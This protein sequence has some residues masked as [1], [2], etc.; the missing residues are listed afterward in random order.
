MHVYI[1]FPWGTQSSMLWP[2]RLNSEPLSVCKIST[3]YLPIV[4]NH[5]GLVLYL[6]SLGRF[7]A[8]SVKMCS[9]STRFKAKT[10]CKLKHV[11]VKAAGDH[12]FIGLGQLA[13][14]SS[15]NSGS[16]PGKAVSCEPLYKKN[17]V[18]VNTK[19]ESMHIRLSVCF[20]RGI[21]LHGDLICFHTAW[22]VMLPET[23]R[24]DGG[25]AKPSANLR[26][27]AALQPV[28]VACRCRDHSWMHVSACGW[29]AAACYPQLTHPGVQRLLP[30]SLNG[31]YAKATSATTKRAVG[32]YIYI[33]LYLFIYACIYKY[34]IICIYSCIR[35]AINQNITVG[36]FASVN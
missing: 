35:W 29:A 27:L 10:P 3:D 23:R 22:F 18:E 7:F 2:I 33:H 21:I 19:L 14:T 1:S 34:N 16:C 28:G 25:T 24:W 26:A 17:K 12:L 8:F 9:K 20:R 13:A 32:M 31:I 6:L 30:A 11:I 5:H 36:A 15:L 4:V